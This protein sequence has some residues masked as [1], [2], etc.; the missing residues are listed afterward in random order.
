MKS[1]IKKSE[2]LVREVEIEVPADRVKEEFDKVYQGY[3]KN[4][5]IKGFR[6]GKAPM[7]VVRQKYAEAA[8]EDVLEKLVEESY[9]KALKEQDVKAATHP[10]FP[11]IQIAE[12]ETLKYTARFEVY[13]EINEIK[14]EGL[15][16]P[17]DKLEVRDPEV[18]TVVNFIRK[19]HYTLS[20]VYGEVAK[21][22][23]FNA[24][25]VKNEDKVGDELDVPV[26]YPEDYGNK[27]LAGKSVK[28]R[29]KINEVNERILPEPNDAFAKQ[30][31]ETETYLELRLKIREDLKKQ[32]EM[33]HEKFKRNEIQ[34]QFIDNNKVEIPEGMISNYLER[35]Y[36]Q[37]KSQNPELEKDVFLNSYRF[38][39]EN[40]LRW[41]LLTTKIANDE[42]IEVSTKDTEKWIKNFADNYNMTMEQ[43]KDTL[44]KSGRI[45]EIRESI[46]DEKI[47][48]KLMARVKYVP[49]EE[50]MPKKK[51]DST[52]EK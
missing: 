23:F 13:P 37:Q 44:S 22:D 16:L 50:L 52:E 29:C 2:G 27:T 10:S 1:E 21:Y 46:M 17:E 12:G 38:M 39:A 6:P 25:M 7:N 48:D 43:A 34:R 18:D 45:Q 14:Y 19:N 4:A 24:D 42:K 11:D 47:M 51:N 20:Y 8:R 49:E 32:K 26:N 9:P 35:T 31:G 30:V 5:K 28:Y 15:K 41:T 33:E 40:G 3:R 36:E